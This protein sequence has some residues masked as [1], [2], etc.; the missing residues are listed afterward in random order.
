[1]TAPNPPNPSTPPGNTSA[2]SAPTKAPTKRSRTTPAQGSAQGQGS[3][4]P[5][6]QAQQEAAEVKRLMTR[7]ANHGWNDVLSGVGDPDRDMLM[8]LTFGRDGRM[9][10]PALDAIYETGGVGAAIIDLVADDATRPRFTL[11]ADDDLSG[12]EK[13]MRHIPVSDGVSG[14]RFGVRLAMNRALKLARLY[15]GAA[16]IVS[17]RDGAPASAPL[18]TAN[19]LGVDRLLVHNRHELRPLR[20]NLRGEVVTYQLHSETAHQG[21]LAPE[22]GRSGGQGLDGRAGGLEVHASRVFPV[23]GTELA[24]HRS[25]SVNGWGDSVLERVMRELRSTMFV[26][27]H[28]TRT[29]ARKNVPVLFTDG[30]DDMMSKDPQA[31][32]AKAQIMMEQMSLLRLLLL[33][34]RDKM[35]NFDTNLSGFSDLLDAFPYRL[36]A[37]ARIPVTR[38]YGMSPAGFSTGDTDQDFYH[39]L[40]QGSAVDL[41]VQPFYQWI[42]E[43]LMLA[44]EGPTQGQAPEVWEMTCAP[45]R[46]PTQKERTEAKTAATNNVVALHSAGLLLPDEAR[47]NLREHYSLDDEAWAKRAAQPAPTPASPSAPTDEQ[48]PDGQATDGQAVNTLTRNAQESVWRR[49]WVPTAEMAEEAR[50]GLEL[51]K[52][53]K[54]G[55]TSIGVRRATQLANRQ[56]VRLSTIRRMFSYFK[57]H[58]V[59]KQAPGWEDR[60]NPSAGWIAWLLW[61]GDAGKAWAERLWRQTEDERAA[62]N[63]T[64]PPTARGGKMG[65]RGQA[66]AHTA[67]LRGR[68]AEPATF[69]DATFGGSGGVLLQGVRLSLHAPE[70][71]SAAQGCAVVCR[72]PEPL[73]ALVYRDDPKRVPHMTLAYFPAVAPGERA[74]FLEVLREAASESSGGRV[75]LSP[76]LSAIVDQDAR[77]VFYQHVHHDTI[78]LYALRSEIIEDAK[79]YGWQATFPDEFM[80]HVTLAYADDPRATFAGQ[81]VSGS[82]FVGQLEVWFGDEEPVVIP[83]GEEEDEGVSPSTQ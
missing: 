21:T 37:A 20:Y 52:T 71:E 63:N 1:M 4:R 69:G 83:L 44:Q 31:I 35:Q 2:P 64:I 29:T 58:A 72:I 46:E 38:L 70:G 33:D 5:K 57:R 81:A 66:L 50:Q 25:A 82:W 76:S 17:A 7:L 54:R 51:R 59:D 68:L 27:D 15:G 73:G 43:L 39:A 55:G 34:G 14:R 9:M 74:R 16:I 77:T 45:L 80:P 24:A 47:A 48:A 41:Y 65:Q 36:A 18:D 30:L 32:R 79:L 28:A 8:R 23:F 78:A 3:A 19:L 42:A 56:P 60:T 26:E 6:T 40:V 62:S 12:I 22:A 53:F 75:F 10:R 67:R 13:A 11:E 61:G 49:T